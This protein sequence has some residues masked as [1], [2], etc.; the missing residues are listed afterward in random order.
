MIRNGEISKSEAKRVLKKYWWVLPLTVIGGTAL[1]LGATLVLP[2]RFTSQTVVLV[3]Q[4]TV[5]P[6][7]VKPVI[8]EQTN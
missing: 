8:T 5:S 6:D 2:K 3:D 1:A 7:L 4:P